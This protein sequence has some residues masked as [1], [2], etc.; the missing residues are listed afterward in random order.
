ME[1]VKRSC[2]TRS[3]LVAIGSFGHEPQDF[4]NALDAM[5]IGESEVMLSLKRSIRTLAS[6]SES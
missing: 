4:D 2:Q 3:Q 1:L 6:S 5:L